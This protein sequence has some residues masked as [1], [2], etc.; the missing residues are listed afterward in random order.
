MS[1]DFIPSDGVFHLRTPTSSYV[2]KI[3]RNR[4]LSHAGWFERLSEWKGAS[5]FPPTDR[6]FSPNPFSESREFSL[7]TLPQEFPTAD[8]TDFRNPAI[9]VVH[10]D[11]SVA[12]DL[13]YRS[14]RIVPGKPSLAGLPATWVER[15]DEADTLEIDLT[16]PV[17]GLAV[18]LSYTVWRD[19]DAISRSSRVTNAGSTSISLEKVLSASIDFPGSD[20]TLM[21]LSGSYSRERFPEFRKLASGMQGIGS[22]RGSSSHSQNPFIALLGPNCGEDSGEAFGFSLVYSGSFVAEVEVEHRGSAR[23]SVGVSPY[24]FCWKLDPGESFQAPEVV[25]VRSGK[26]L[27]GMSRTYH[28][29]YRERLCRGEWR[30]RARPVVVNNWEATYFTFSEKKLLALADEAKAL[31]IETFVLDDG[32]FGKRESDLSS[33]GDWVTNSAKIPGGSLASF[34]G[35]LKDRG[36]EFGLWVEPEMVSPDSDLY[37]AHP[38]WCLHVAGRSRSVGRSQL[39]LDLSRAD[40]RAHLVDVFSKIFTSAPISFVKWDMNRNM[41]EVGSALVGPDRASETTHRYMLGLYEILETLTGKFP[42]ILFESCS[43]GGGRYDPGMLYYMPQTWTSDN[44]DAVSRVW[45][46]LGTSVVYPASTMSCHVSASPNHQ[47]GRISSMKMR[48]DVAMNGS[49]GYELDLCR[50]DDSEKKEIAAQVE[51]YKRERETILFG[52]HYR[53]VNPWDNPAFAAWMTVSKDRREA[54]VTCVWLAP[55]SN[56]PWSLL[57]LRGLDPDARYFV[58]ARNAAF[59]GAELM[60]AGLAVR[61]DSSNPESLRMRLRA[62]E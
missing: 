8:R 38:D 52:D 33:L 1:I 18:T 44:T 59:T 19:R 61:Y 16:D 51:D 58:D 31:G 32:W 45:I 60:R 14:H 12:L 54:F 49:F 20:F 7:D 34:A 37:R 47:V 40:V 27:G 36:L 9:E 10:D 5:E 4:Y 26:G 28:D 30:A 55:V 3:V 46:Q 24:H 23:V 13:W 41:T 11:G 15:D 62:V 43:G 25:M 42:H 39:V 53:L 2:M 22:R 29:L 35:M 21:Q 6:G 17:S 50:L 57:R 48:G 56:G